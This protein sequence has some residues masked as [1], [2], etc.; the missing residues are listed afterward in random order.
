[1]AT[2]IS[3]SNASLS[4]NIRTSPLPGMVG[5]EPEPPPSGERLRRLASLQ[6][7]LLRHALSFPAVRRVV[8]STCS[9]TEE[10]N[11]QVRRMMMFAGGSRM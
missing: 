2:G 7:M 1:M 5:R 10:E 3:F 8:Y 9:V 11:E 6:G 4:P